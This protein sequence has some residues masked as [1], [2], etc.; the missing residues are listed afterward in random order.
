MLPYYIKLW[1]KDVQYYSA[2]GIYDTYRKISNISRTNSQKL[3]RFSPRLAAVFAQSI[4]VR[5]Y[6]ENKDVVVAAPTGDAPTVS[7]WSIIL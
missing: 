4:E 2:N 5:C 7:E 1:N 6:I 3:K